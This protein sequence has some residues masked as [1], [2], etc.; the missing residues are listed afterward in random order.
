MNDCPTGF[1]LPQDP[2]GKA[3]PLNALITIS[4]IDVHGHYGRYIR[5]G[6]ASLLDQLSSGDAAEVVRRA[7]AVNIGLTTVSPPLTAL[8]PR[9]QA[10]AVAGNIEAARVVAETPR[11][12]Q[13]VV[14]DPRRTET[15][16]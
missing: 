5:A 2:I 7:S 1:P 10:D 6:D 12:K 14:I 9:F 11:L 16:A 13:Y 8:L 4:A 3:P 15:Y